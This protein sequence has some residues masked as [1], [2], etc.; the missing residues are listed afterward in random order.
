M[1][2]SMR[3]EGSGTPTT[4][5]SPPLPPFSPIRSAVPVKFATSRPVGLEKVAP[6]QL[7]NGSRLCH[8]SF[9]D[10]SSVV[11]GGATLGITL[12]RGSCGV[13]SE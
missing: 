5:G 7:M 3:V 8:F 6:L 9:L 12:R 4:G 10:R 13:C 2:K 11:V 1:P